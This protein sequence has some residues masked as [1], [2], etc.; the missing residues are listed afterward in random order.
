MFFYP[1]NRSYGNVG[2]LKVEEANQTS[3]WIRVGRITL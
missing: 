2:G 1:E 3:R